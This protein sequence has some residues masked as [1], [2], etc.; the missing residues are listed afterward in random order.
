MKWDPSHS[1]ELLGE[2]GVSP[3][4]HEKA[5]GKYCNL[6]MMP[7]A[8]ESWSLSLYLEVSIHPFLFACFWFFSDKVSLCSLGCLGTHS[9][10]QA[11]LKLRDRLPLPLQC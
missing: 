7:V 10:D 2:T 9:V 6:L 8:S 1:H 11:S 3:N 5:I 4:A